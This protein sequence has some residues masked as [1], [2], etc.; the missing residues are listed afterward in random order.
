MLLDPD[1]KQLSPCAIAKARHALGISSVM[2]RN[3]KKVSENYWERTVE[4]VAKNDPKNCKT[5]IADAI[6][7]Y[8]QYMKR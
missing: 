5:S 1:G 7:K 4:A 6:D 8:D 2:P 3:N